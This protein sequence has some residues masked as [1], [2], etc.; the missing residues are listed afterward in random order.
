MTHDVKKTFAVSERAFLLIFMAKGGVRLT[1]IGTTCRGVGGS[2]WSVPALG[3]A[4]GP[5]GDTRGRSMWNPAC[6]LEQPVEEQPPCPG[7]SSVEPKCE[8]VEVVWELRARH[9]TLLRDEQP[10]LYER[11]HAVG[12]G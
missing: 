8:L 4:A 2:S 7:S 1:Q 12:A 9:G 10:A 11:D 5:L 6:L 3:A